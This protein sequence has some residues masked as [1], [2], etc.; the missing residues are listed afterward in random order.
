VGDSKAPQTDITTNNIPIT[1]IELLS[2]INNATSKTE[3]PDRVSKATIIF[4]LFTLSA[5]IP[6]NGES[7]IVGTVEKA[8]ILANT[9]AEPVT[10]K[11]YI[12]KANFSIKFPNNELICPKTSNVK[13]GVNNLSFI[14]YLFL[15][16][17]TKLTF[18]LDTFDMHST[19]K[20]PAFI[21]TE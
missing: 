19:K 10:S 1:G 20:G 14:R 3:I 13:L 2:F 18:S 9:I 15:K 8:N 5:R 6:P 12:D 21:P 4:L 17:F 7:N 11:T 16:K